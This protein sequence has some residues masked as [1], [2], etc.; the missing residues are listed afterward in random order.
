MTKKIQMMERNEATLTR[1][2]I[3]NQ[4]KKTDVE[5]DETKASA[6]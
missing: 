4:Q 1:S 5:T 6:G 3:F 2:S